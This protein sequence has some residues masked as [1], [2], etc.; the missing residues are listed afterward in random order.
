[1]HLHSLGLVSDLRMEVLQTTLDEVE[2]RS[3]PGEVPRATRDAL[4]SLM[5]RTLMELKRSDPE[6]SDAMEAREYARRL[7]RQGLA[8]SQDL[9]EATLV[10]AGCLGVPTSKGELALVVLLPAGGYL[11]G[12]IANVAL[13]RAVFLLRRARTVEDVVAA[14]ERISLR[15]AIARDSRELMGLIQERKVEQALAERLEA[16]LLRELAEKGI[17]HAP[18]RIVAIE[19]VGDRVV[20]LERGSSSAGLTHILERH[21]G[22]FARRGM[23]EAQIPEALMSALRANKV[24]G[25]QAGRP[26]YE[27]V[28]NGELQHIAITVSE[29]GFVVGANPA[30][31]G[32]ALR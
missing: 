10:I 2:A 1:V 18:E 20:F 9:G 3:A 16:S 7:N 11:V 5:R 26:I 8:I 32:A 24:V 14:S 19:K 4:A 6:L 30:A 23:N 21:G 31:L 27:V 29:N 12:K 25:Y 28:F 22:D 13:K 15:F 17:K